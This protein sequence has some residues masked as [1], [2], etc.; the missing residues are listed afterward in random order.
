MSS[1]RARSRF[2]GVA[3]PGHGRT[4]LKGVLVRSSVRAAFV[5]LL[6]GLWWF[7]ADVR[8]TSSIIL[9]SPGKVFG[10]LPSKVASSELMSSVELTVLQVLGAFGLSA[11]AGLLLGIGVG[12]SDHWTRVVRPLVVWGQTVP[13]ILLYPLCILIFGLGSS[14]KI[15]FAGIYGAFPVVLNTFAGLEGEA[16][17]YRQVGRAYGARAH[18]M[19]WKVALPAA[20]PFILTG[21]RLA[22]ALNIIGVLAGELLGS[23]GGL[24]YEI[25]AAE[26]TFDTVGLYVY[27]IVTLVLVVVVNAVIGRG[28]SAAHDRGGL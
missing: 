8:H 27:I 1:R 18:E 3:G 11:V 21:L 2:A 10:S 5:L 9:A 28:E 12:M 17:R 24:G 26:G 6:L 16:R 7:E 14:S 13:I 15:V 25:G 4:N 23:T 22:A 20:R 19:A